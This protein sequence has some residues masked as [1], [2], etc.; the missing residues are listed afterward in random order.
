MKKTKSL[1]GKAA[2]AGIAAIVIVGGL[3]PS[4]RAETATAT[5]A[6]T[7]AADEAR[8]EPDAAAKLLDL[9]GKV[10]AT[11]EQVSAI[12]SVVDGL[13]KIKLSGYVQARY[14]GREDSKDGLTSAG[15]PATTSQFLVRR[16]RLKATYAGQLSEFMLQI[17]ATGRGVALRDAEAT[18]IEPWTGLGLRLTAGQ[19]KYPFGYEVIQSSSQREMPE[20]ARVIRTLFPGERD[21]GLRFQGSWNVLRL[22]AALVNG[23]TIEDSIYGNNDQNAY[24]D[25]VAR[26]GVDLD[27]VVFGVSGYTGR[28][29][30]TAIGDEDT[31]YDVFD[32]QR[33]G[34]DAQVYL[35]LLPI[36]GTAVKGELVAAKDVKETTPF[37]FYVFLLQ[38]LGE[39]AAVFARYDLYDPD[40]DDAAEDDST[41]TIGVGAHY[42]FSGNFKLTASWE[43]PIS[44]VAD[45]AEDKKDDVVTAQL[46]A[47]F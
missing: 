26:L 20:R 22:S 33:L 4:A 16:G 24:K 11:E 42:F 32:K 23:N 27:W 29:V 36:G 41:Q 5:T 35:D 30:S 12:Q 15:R 2:L 25:L 19:F 37:G 43:H 31:T 47:M 40:T 34:L 21:R 8:A 3:T 28:G 17:D 1:E 39:H 46:Q 10:Q 7:T 6:A 13:S 14:E 44:E 9:E 38:N 45:G 18:F